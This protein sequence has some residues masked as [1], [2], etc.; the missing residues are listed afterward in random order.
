MVKSDFI[1][2]TT[3]KE[4][5]AKNLIFSLDPYTQKIAFRKV[6]NAYRRGSSPD[7]LERTLK[8]L[9][10]ISISRTASRASNI[11]A[12]SYIGKQTQE[13]LISP[14]IL[15]SRSPS[16]QILKTQGRIERA[17]LPSWINRT[18]HRAQY[19]STADTSP[20]SDFFDSLLFP[21]ATMEQAKDF[22]RIRKMDRMRANFARVMSG[23]GIR[24]GD[25][26][27]PEERQAE[28]ARLN[29]EYWEK[30]QYR[31]NRQGPDVPPGW[32]AEGAKRR[33][34]GLSNFEQDIL[35]DFEKEFKRLSERYGG[36]KEGEKM[37]IQIMAKNNIFL[38]SISKELPGLTK[39]ILKAAP[40]IKMGLGAGS[41]IFGA[42]RYTLSQQR[43]WA[44]LSTA[45]G[46]MGINPA[47]AIAA[48]TALGGKSLGGG[49]GSLKLIGNWETAIGR[50]MRGGSTEFLADLEKYGVDVR[51]SGF[52]GFATGEEIFTAVVSKIRQY[53]RSGDK[54]L[55]LA[56]ADISGIDAAVYEAMDHVEDGDVLGWIRKIGKMSG[57]D[58][59]AKQRGDTIRDESGE[60]TIFEWA[61]SRLFSRA[62]QP[63]NAPEALLSALSFGLIANQSASLPSQSVGAAASYSGHSNVSVNVGG[64]VVNSDNAERLGAD[65]ISGAMTSPGS[66]AA[67][68]NSLDPMTMK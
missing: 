37:A 48:N 66:R 55:A 31:A 44:G 6:F 11:K 60:R 63:Q 68:A 34:E 29:K 35:N 18:R 50:M 67:I 8:A 28:A 17:G 5:W 33:H 3:S 10:A 1:P 25:E 53:K 49:V 45:G 7:L 65:I 54:N 20:R 64:V 32:D 21:L 52:G 36:G 39:T 41:A 46:R 58:A 47:M 26:A 4:D 15:Q 16:E 59:V 38:K 22:A 27:T 57:T 12:F 62:N 23:S 13:H 61:K 19:E 51:G 2:S 30:E 56:L 24:T 9:S 14:K 43:G 42:W 40:S